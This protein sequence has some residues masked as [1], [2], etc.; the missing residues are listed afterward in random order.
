MTDGKIRASH[1]QRRALVYVRQSSPSQV[2]HNRESTR[3]QYALAD[4]ARDLGWPHDQITIVDED[5]GPVR[6]HRRRA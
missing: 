6:L 5:L 1:R 2:E 3:R 4:R